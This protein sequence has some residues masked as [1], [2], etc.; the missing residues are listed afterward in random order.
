MS[1]VLLLPYGTS[2]ST[3]PF[4][5]LGRQL[6]AHGHRVTMITAPRYEALAKQAGLDFSA[7]PNDELEQMLRDPSLWKL[8]LG[9]KTAYT[10]GGRAAKDYVAAAEA[11]MKSAGRADLIMAPMICFG[12]RVLREKLGI[13]LVT[14]HLY[15]MMII[16]GHRPPV[17]IPPFRWLRSMPLIVRRTILRFPNPLDLFA[18]GPVRRCSIAHGV[19]PRSLWK[20]WWDSPDGVLALF[21]DWFAAPQP[22]WPQNFLQWDFP[23]EDMG[24][25]Q[26]VEDALARF[27]AQDGKPVFFTAGTGHFHAEKFFATA[28][29]LVEA[30]GCRAVFITPRPEQ[31]PSGLPDNVFVTR[32]APFRQILPQARAFVHHGGIGTTSQCLAAGVPQLV[33]PMS[34][35][36]PDNADRVEQLGVGLQIS[37]SRFSVAKALPLLRRCLEDETIAGRAR[38][39][40]LRMQK[41]RDPAALV[42]WLEARCTRP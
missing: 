28:A 32:Y 21:P 25:E 36:Q 40:A 19:R 30:L 10:H 13:P 22:D 11:V 26:P 41:Q 29:K 15:P 2:G 1:H 42:R 23:L 33:V 8:G 39:H 31:L 18:M 24:G 20:E 7:T 27:L 35:D 3:Y 9:L 37:H 12:A 16:K 6:L 5:W 14:T 34:L 38:E 17:V 4:I